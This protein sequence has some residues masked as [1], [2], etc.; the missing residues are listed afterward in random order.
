MEGL[1]IFIIY[2]M[3]GGLWYRGV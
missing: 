2:I 3:T 1:N